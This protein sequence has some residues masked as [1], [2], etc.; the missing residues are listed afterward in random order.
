MSFIFLGNL[1][2]IHT[3]EMLEINIIVNFT[4]I[5]SISRRDNSKKDK[6]DPV[7]IPKIK[8]YFFFVFLLLLIPYL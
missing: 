3:N 8:A 7:L 5:S 1:Y 6:D 2:P 4:I